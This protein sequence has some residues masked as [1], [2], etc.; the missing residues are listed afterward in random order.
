MEFDETVKKKYPI[1][2]ITYVDYINDETDL[3]S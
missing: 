3:I 2:N 1:L